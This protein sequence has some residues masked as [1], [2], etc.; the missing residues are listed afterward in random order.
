LNTSLLHDCQTKK[1]LIEY[2]TKFD[3]DKEHKDAKFEITYYEAFSP[4]IILGASK[5]AELLSRKP[6]LKL[7]KEDVKEMMHDMK[8]TYVCASDEWEVLSSVNSTHQT[9]ARNKEM[10][11]DPDTCEYLDKDLTKEQTDRIN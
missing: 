5:K 1:K 2:A 7:E 9:L 8:L 3:C 6:L 11:V 4:Y 10:L